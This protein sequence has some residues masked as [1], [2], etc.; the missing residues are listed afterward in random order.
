MPEAMRVEEESTVVPSSCQ[1]IAANLAPDRSYQ[2][3][4]S[5]R[6]RS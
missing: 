1:L 3:R 6:L 5:D 2:F 4:K